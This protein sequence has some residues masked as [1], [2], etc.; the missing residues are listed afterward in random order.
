MRI[1][2]FIDA[3]D[4]GGAETLL[5]SYIPLLGEHEH[6]VVVLN[7]PNVYN[8]AGYDYI[9]LN[10]K[11]VRGLLSARRAVRNII[12]EKKIDIVHSHSFWTNIISRLATPKKIKLFNHYHFAD[13]ETMRQKKS[14][15]RMILMDRMIRHKKLLRIAVSDYVAGMLSKNFGSAEIKV[16]PNFIA[17]DTVSKGKSIRDTNV[18]RI[19]A[20]GNCNL[21]KNYD[22]L[23]RVFN[24]LKE[25]PV[26]IDVMGGG[27]LLDYY[28]NEVERL[29]L[30]KVKF[31][32]M[33]S[34]VRARLPHYD[35]FL[36][37]SFSESFGMVVL[38]AVCAGLPLML[39]D[40]PAYKEIA[41]V[42]TCFFDPKN[43]N[44]LVKKIIQ[45]LN[46]QNEVNDDEY[47]RTL[48]KY[49]AG[50]FLVELRSLYKNSTLAAG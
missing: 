43:E 39:S 25:H 4:Y 37:T 38:E 44:D 30:K 9:E 8:K 35:L 24:A 16:I 3:L 34:A 45:F 7:G 2:H 26:T 49:S 32:G 22:Y 33:E 5:M 23:L 20:V 36:S 29:G 19:V 41:P 11:P 47:K 40:I 27:P 42:G 14:V 15:K 50:N 46:A 12:R 17:C 1:L 13:Y 10:H 31:Y 6:T 28:R 18:L 21:E 48:Q